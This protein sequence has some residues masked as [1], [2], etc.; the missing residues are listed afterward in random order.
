MVPLGDRRLMLRQYPPISVESVRYRHVTVFKITNTVAATVQ[1]RVSVTSTGLKLVRVNAGS[2][3][4]AVRNARY[5]VP[6]SFCRNTWLAGERAPRTVL[7]PGAGLLPRIVYARLNDP[8]LPT[9]RGRYDV[10][11]PM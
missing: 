1:A 5:A 9:G 3:P 2:K 6:P 8:E 11:R 4:P 10:S 7:P